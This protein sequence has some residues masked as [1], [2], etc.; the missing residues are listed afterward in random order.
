M[1]GIAKGWAVDQIVEAVTALGYENCYVDW[2][3]DIKVHS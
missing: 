2:G 3:A 1:G